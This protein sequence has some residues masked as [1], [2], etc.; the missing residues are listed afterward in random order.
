MSEM[1]GFAVL[2]G[3]VVRM[4]DTED[5]VLRNVVDP[6]QP[7]DRFYFYYYITIGEILDHIGLR[8]QYSS[9]T[10]PLSS[11][12]TPFNKEGFQLFDNSVLGR[13][14]G[15]SL[16]PRARTQI[17]ANGVLVPGS[18]WSAPCCYITEVLGPEDPVYDLDSNPA[19]KS[20]EGAFGPNN[21]SDISYERGLVIASSLWC[22]SSVTRTSTANVL[23][24]ADR[25]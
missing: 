7:L 6:T 2:S 4:K 9:Y 13:T 3:T 12:K 17:N 5:R 21:N 10:I 20:H 19:I 16:G 18:G 8:A 23:L 14:G 22:T 24:L 15:G 11:T 25:P 1:G